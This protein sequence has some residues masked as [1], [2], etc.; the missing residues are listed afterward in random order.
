MAGTTT[1]QENLAHLYTK[2]RSYTKNERQ[3]YQ[4]F[5]TDFL[6]CFGIVFDDP[7]TLPFE[8][9]TG[10]GFAD[11]FIKDVVIIEMKDKNKIRTKD[12]LVEQLPQAI[13]YWEGKGK[14][15]PFLVLCN[16]S[17][18]VIFD[19]RDSSTHHLKLAEL[20]YKVESFGFLLSISSVFAPEQ[21]AVTRK[22]AKI[23]GQL[24][25]SLRSRLT[26]KEEDVDLFV[27]QCL[28]CLF[29]EDIGYLPMETFSN[30][31]RRIKDGEDN[32]ANVL[33]TLFK[34]MDEQDTDRKKGRFENVRYFNGPLFR[35]KPEIVLNDAEVDFLWQSC[36][37]DWKNVRPEIF[38][39]LFE[40][41]Q[42][43]VSRHKDGMHF[44]SEED[45]LKVVGP[46]ILEPWNEKFAKCKTL[47]DFRSLHRNLKS[48][49][50]LDPA[51]GSGNFLVVAYRELK[52]IEERVFME[53][54]RLSGES[55]ARVQESMEWYPVTNL[56]GIEI[57]EF[58]SFLTRVS[59]WI[60][61]KLVKN[62][63]K[64][65]EPDL[66]LEE[67]K[68]IVSADALE[69]KWD[70]VDV[71][72]GNPP[73]IG[74]KQIKEAR[75]E[76]Y[77]KWLSERFPTHNKMSDYCTYW[78]EKVAEDVRPGVRVGLVCTNSV[79]QTN[80]RLASLDKVVESGGTIYN[81]ISTQKWSGEA[82]VHVSIVNF[83]HCGEHDGPRMLD[84][85]PVDTISSRLLAFAPTYEAEKIPDNLKKAFQGVTALG[86][87]FVL[88]NATA[89][90]LMKK[91]PASKQVLKKFYTASSVVDDWKHEP[92]EWIIDFQ[93]WPLEKAK[94]YNAAFSLL[95]ERIASGDKKKEKVKKKRN[96]TR[97]SEAGGWW[98]LWRARPGLRKALTGL[99]RFVLVSRH[100]KY[101]IFALVKGKAA[102]PEDSTVAIAFND[103][104][105]L[106]VLQ[107]KF[108][109]DWH[110]Y[111]CST[112]KGDPRYTNTFVFETFPFPDQIDKKV[113]PT[114]KEI[115]RYRRQACSTQ[116]CSLTDLYNEMT[117]GGHD[118]L[119][120]L[121]TK[122]D[123]A[124][125]RSYGF[126]RGKIGSYRDVILF[127]LD[128]N[129]S[130]CAEAKSK[131][132]ASDLEPTAKEVLAKARKALAKAD[133]K[134]RKR[135]S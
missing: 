89:K 53:C 108:H 16:F 37:M 104:S 113:A 26:G 74:C 84:G 14:H 87:A 62:Q 22:S 68:H 55:Y 50:V 23:M 43:K 11:C 83:V 93:N 19:T 100:T 28:F 21:E 34:M 39:A 7:N 98:K 76:D 47:S 24:Y 59:L 15:V 79:S 49:R 58:P 103:H 20:E 41:S 44:T 38:G 36:Q 102:I 64:L 109:T 101:P 18:F 117:E 2:W 116:K 12:Q 135:R 92:T 86:K 33:S 9:N 27:L 60:T 97:T 128:L 82:K 132:A 91:S 94:K 115:E 106:G 107:S 51:C 126:P 10:K 77:A 118:L 1:V 61:K 54:K 110:R 52:R 32:S 88:D 67:L 3:G 57:N 121:H 80:S 8:E 71:V 72:V 112:I 40:S 119:R 123:E 124:V 45:I 25:R 70:D 42:S 85:E 63:H 78:F 17:D 65:T 81:A 48:Y 31:V 5:L 75:G 69:I 96:K 95:K 73:Y 129:Q 133:K 99:D 56:Y 122:L 114:M 127:L 125:A 90:A 66:P 35:K 29:S 6:H 4:T 30:C 13:R 134:V 131:K 105:Q 46:S 120:S 111:Q 130:Y